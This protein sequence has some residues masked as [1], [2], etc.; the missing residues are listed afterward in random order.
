MINFKFQPSK[1]VRW[2]F[3]T[4]RAAHHDEKEKE[5]TATHLVW[6]PA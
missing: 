5:K 4:W 3:K 2:D 1:R 6:T